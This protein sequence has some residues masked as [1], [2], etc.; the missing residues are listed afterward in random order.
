[1]NG[2]GPRSLPCGLLGALALIIAAE[3]FA[4]RH[5]NDLFLN[6]EVWSS[7]HVA[8][9]ARTPVPGPRI[10]CIGDSLVQV[11][12]ASPV[13][14][15]RTGIRTY[16]FAISGGQA[17]TSYFLLRRT[18]AAGDEPAAILV[19]FFGGLLV[20]NP[21]ATLHPWPSFGS[22]GECLDLACTAR[23][24]TFLAKVM[25][26]KTL[27]T[28]RAR[29][30]IRDN[31]L[32]ALHGEDQSARHHVPPSLRRNLALNR[33]GLLCPPKPGRDHDLDKWTQIHF[34][35]D[36]SCEAVNESYLRR[37]LALASEHQV[38]VFWLLPP[39]QPAVQER[40][41]A[42]GFDARYE[43]F[44]R[45]LQ[46]EY[47]IVSVIDGR[48]AGYDDRVFFDPHHLGRDGA[49]V[50]SAELAR[51]LGRARG[52]SPGLAAW[53]AL[54]AYRARP[55]EEPLEDVDQSRLAFQRDRTRR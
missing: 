44:V 24:A 5:E 2:R 29:L 37:F 18:L 40:C 30:A 4:A 47:P 55:I 41:V 11:G 33:G 39:I 1:M 12:V 50:Y 34:P 42:N 16:N 35:A 15:N 38:P 22:L 53:T 14:E 19:D 54:P 9:L 13:I 45:G 32:A 43:A 26:A 27:P 17:A 28:V 51:L 36:W 7:A 25:V 20:N 52:R 8:E 10:V 31:V 23:D 21:A 46:A 6:L 48:Y 49:A 3:R